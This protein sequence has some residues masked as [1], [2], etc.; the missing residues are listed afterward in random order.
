MNDKI[1]TRMIPKIHFRIGL[2]LFLVFLAVFFTFIALLEGFKIDH[3]KLGEIKIEKLYLKWDK[4]LLIKASKIDLSNITTDDTPVTLKPLSKLPSTIR[5]IERWIESIDI[6]ILQYHDIKAAI[7]YHKNTPGTVTIQEGNI[8]YSS[9]FV[10]DENAFHFTLPHM[11]LNNAIIAGTLDVQLKAQ[12][13]HADVILSLPETPDLHINMLGNTDTLAISIRADKNITTLRPLI[14]FIA[15]DPVIAPWV[16]DYAKAESLTIHQLQGTFHYDKPEELLTSLRADASVA[17]G[18]YTFAQGIDPIKAPK[19]TLNF[20]DGKLYIYPQNGTFYALPTE[21]SYLYIDF[22]TEHTEL[23][24]F[25]KTSHAMLND[26]I[27]ELLRYYNIQLPIKQTAGECDVDLNLS[28]NLYSLDTTAQGIFKPTASALLLEQIPLR[29]EGGIVILDNTHVRFNDFIAHYGANVAH[30]RVNGEYD[31]HNEHGNVS[32][33]AYDVSVAGDNRMLTLFDARNPL[34]IN[35]IIAPDHDTLSVGA[36][37]WNLLGQPL[38][39]N[40]FHAPFDYHRAYV[41]VQSIPFAI[42]DKVKGN[43]SAVFN[44]AEKKNDLRLRLEDFHVGEM[45]LRDTPFDIDIRYDSAITTLS[46]PYASAWSIH[47][48]P[49]LVSPFNASFKDDEITFERIDMVLGDILKGNFTGKY[50][51]DS[52]Q[53]S[54]RLSDMIPLTPRVVPLIDTKEFIDFTV[55]AS[56]EEIKLNAESL[57]ASF[58]TIPKGWKISLADI[59]LLSGKSPLLRYYDVNNGHLNLFYTG[60]SS[61]YTFNGGINYPFALMMVN[62]KPI[63]QYRFSGAYQDDRSVIRINDRLVLTQMPDGITIRAKNAG[64]NMPQLSKFLSRHGENNSSAAPESTES[65]PIRIHA[66][67]TYLYLTKDRKILADTLYATLRDDNMD[68]S[69]NHLQGSASLKIRNGKFYIDGNDFNDNFMEHLFTFGDFIGGKFSFQAQGDSDAFEGIM[70]VENTILKEYKILNNVLAFVNTVP[71]LATFSLPNYS[72]QGLPVKEGYA[73]FVYNKGMLNVDNFTVNSREIKILGEGH[74]D[75]K[76]QT[77]QGALT[78]KTD[79]GS[80]FSKIPMV[81]YIIFGDDGSIST[82]VTVKGKLDNPTVE[83]A[84]AK[85]IVTAPFNILKRTLVY[86]FLWMLP[87][88]KKK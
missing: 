10:L 42:A 49:L 3:L 83:T 13:L 87:D 75:L 85:E 38:K 1:I 11:K 79:L 73:H 71:S 16:V 5:F 39:V 2:F 17:M 34:R 78:L 59:S 46:S 47:K 61:R 53:G 62:D 18:E 36:S 77:L 80:K 7:S 66:S 60:E 76:A 27:I 86:P 82:T 28:V 15:L 58:S 31:A 81:G 40:A 23:K 22:T 64:I 44:G 67:N 72:T 45:S 54:L 12:K 24:A 51:L 52:K 48:L 25:I 70:R 43:I 69:L 4:A 65:V 32:I 19:V 30:A 8:T 63:S 26:P 74:A 88:E 33:D 20:T 21:K 55:D 14:E 84:I 9:T 29:S 50:R 6:N 56:G 37:K 41:A 57:K 35:Y 68:V